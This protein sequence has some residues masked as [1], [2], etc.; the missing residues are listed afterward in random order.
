MK[1]GIASI[2]SELKEFGFPKRG[3]VLITGTSEI[4]QT[5]T[6]KEIA[7]NIST[8]YE[9][10]IAISTEFSSW[11]T[12]EIASAA[13]NLWHLE[14][15]QE[16]VYKAISQICKS[17]NRQEYPLVFIDRILNTG[18]LLATGG[19]RKLL[20]DTSGELTIVNCVNQNKKLA[21][22]LEAI[23]ASKAIM[24]LKIQEK[25]N[26]NSSSIL[27]SILGPYMIQIAEKYNVANGKSRTVQKEEAVIDRDKL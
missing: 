5:A 1:S 23:L 22:D 14:V 24:T 26:G 19:I 10:G 15:E 21:F 13:P 12:K 6:A 11:T 27:L 8:H 9:K 7:K 20:E 16:E 25:V 4:F 18:S 3:L 2:D 17:T